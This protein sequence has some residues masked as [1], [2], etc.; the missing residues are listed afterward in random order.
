V[1][2]AGEL[3]G[4]AR[5]ELTALWES[6]RSQGFLGP[7]PVSAH[8][9]HSLA[10]T[11]LITTSLAELAAGRS[12][13][14]DLGSGAGVPGLLLAL[15]FPDWSLTLVEGSAKRAAFLREA[16]GRLDLESRVR[17]GAGTAEETGRSDL[18]TAVDVV[19]ARSFGPP[20]VTAEVAA[21]LLR[22]GGSLVVSDQPVWDATRWPVDGLGLLGLGPARSVR[23]SVGMVVVEQVG[24]CPDRFPRRTGIP[25]KRPLF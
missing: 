8:V 17:V 13:V 25:R 16:L 6:A 4:E 22:T 10:F 7:G 3:D 18:R 15:T 5:R 11:E 23:G 14:V 1:P 24:D 20:A 2:G 9:D 12:E 21:P 19:V